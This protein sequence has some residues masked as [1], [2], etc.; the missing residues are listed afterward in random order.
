MSA[1]S[2]LGQIGDPSAVPGLILALEDKENSVQGNA[3]YALGQIGDPSAV[4][5]LI[6]VL[7]RES[8]GTPS[9]TVREALEKLSAARDAELMMLG[10]GRIDGNDDQ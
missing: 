7:L 4:Q 2:A 10:G 9:Q 3:A 5:P 6:K 1:A 8:N